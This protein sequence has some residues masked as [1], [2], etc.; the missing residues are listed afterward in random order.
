MQEL[1]KLFASGFLLSLSLCA[2]LGVVNIAMV[3]AGLTRGLTAALVLGLGSCV[4]DLAYAVS[5]LSVLGLV[6]AHRGVRIGLWLGGTAVLAWLAF[7]MLRESRHP[8]P[9]GTENAAQAAGEEYRPARQFARGVVLALSSPSAILWFAA[10]G[11]SVIAA[12]ATGRA[13]LWPFLGGFFAAGVCWSVFI[14][15]LTGLAHRRLSTGFIRGLALMSA[16]LFCYFAA[17]VFV[18][19]YR[20][21]I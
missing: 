1:L 20:E 4:G 10:V 19:G 14:A 8:H 16:I 9:L 12:H 11:G 15:T 7:K 18:N 17:E 13:A 6:L 3:R 2:D 5:S 21:F